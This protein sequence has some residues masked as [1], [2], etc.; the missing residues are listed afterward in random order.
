MFTSGRLGVQV[1]RMLAVPGWCT[2]LMA[3]CLS[4]G[5]QAVREVF[6]LS[7]SR[8]LL[9]PAA[10]SEYAHTRHA[11]AAHR[12]IWIFLW[13]ASAGLVTT[14]VKYFVVGHVDLKPTVSRALLAS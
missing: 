5:T 9:A 14:Q 12:C 13:L 6:H 3:L 4:E 8:Q 2:E 11:C 7:V 1:V 10:Q